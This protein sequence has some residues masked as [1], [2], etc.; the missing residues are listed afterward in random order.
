MRRGTR[1]RARAAGPSA[2]GCAVHRRRTRRGHRTCSSTRWCGNS[3]RVFL[4][5]DFEAHDR[6]AA[7]A[8][9][10]TVARGDAD[11]AFSYA[12]T[13]YTT[14]VA[15]AQG[16]EPATDQ[17]RGVAALQLA[18]IHLVVGRHVTARSV[19]DLAN[20]RVG[21]GPGMSSTELEAQM[22][23]DAYGI[24]RSRIRLESLP[25]DEAA[26]RLSRGTLDA[27]FQIAS[28]PVESVRRAL[29]EGAVLL[30]LE[31]PVVDALRRES[32]FL[33]PTVIPA[34]VYP[35]QSA[36]VHTLGVHNLLVCRRDLDEDLVHDLTR[37]LF[38]LLPTLVTGQDSLRLVNLQQA[39]ATPIPLHPGAARYYRERELAR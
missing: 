25:F 14:Y 24:D 9:V 37:R 34:H 17:I 38:E 2:H 8:N 23:L 29:S 1:V 3:A 20:L 39:P 32:V 31:G 19:R 21:I 4:I 27:F 12:D 22:L 26:D 15:S 35:G 28:D 6:P 13:A 30:P 5:L 33:N 7:V 16:D 36:A 11:F 18:P 10:T